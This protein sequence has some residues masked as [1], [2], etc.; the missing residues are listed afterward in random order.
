[1]I[2]FLSTKKPKASILN[3]LLCINV[4]LSL[5]VNCKNRKYPRPYLI[6]LFLIIAPAGGS[7]LFPNPAGHPAWGSYPIYVKNEETR[8]FGFFPWPTNA[9]LMSSNSCFTWVA[10]DIWI[11]IGSEVDSISAAMFTVSP[12]TEKCGI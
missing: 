3:L 12:N 8:N 1:M 7:N 5:Y 11:R 2:P 6:L 10:C 9:Y 4:T